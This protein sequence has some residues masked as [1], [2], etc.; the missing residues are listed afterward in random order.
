[1]WG[2]VFPMCGEFVWGYV[3]T[4][5]S[6]QGNKK[7]YQACMKCKLIW[8]G[9]MYCSGS[10]FARLDQIQFDCSFDG[11]PAIIDIEFV[12]DALG[13]CADRTQ[14]DHEFTGDLG[15]GKLSLEQAEN[16]KLTPAE[17]LDQRLRNGR[18][19]ER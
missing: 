8:Q 15:T 5:A 19:G 13:M 2:D 10:A 4:L 11:C 7:T 1:M 9:Y 6:G 3:E 17:R 18:C 16:F 12:V 14:A